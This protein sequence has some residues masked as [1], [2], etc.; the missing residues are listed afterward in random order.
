ML[1]PHSIL[2]SYKDLYYYLIRIFLALVFLASAGPTLRVLRTVAVINH[3]KDED[4]ALVFTFFL[5]YVMVLSICWREFS[6]DIVY[7]SERLMSS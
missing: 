3:W 6:T 5:F 4:A 1:S 7:T 2:W